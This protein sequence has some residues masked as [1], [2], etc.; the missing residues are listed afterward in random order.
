M[1]RTRVLVVDDHKA[2]CAA[3]AARLDLEPDLQVVGTASS[4]G[5]ALRLAQLLRPDLITLDA[6]LAA[7]DGVELCARTTELSPAPV[8]AFLSCVEDEKRVAA[9]VRAGSVVWISK[10]ASSEHVVEVLRRAVRGEAYLPRGMLAGTLRALV[11][12]EPEPEPVSR[13]LAALTPRE[14]EVLQGLMEGLDR[15]ALARRL[16]LS[17]NTVRTHVQNVRTKLGVTSSLEAVALARRE[18]LRC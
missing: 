1:D 17:P 5:Q 3:L 18:G 9:A 13:R 7:E 15:D 8:V 10:D 12:A 14:V 2:F 4:A 11:R 16:F 6:D